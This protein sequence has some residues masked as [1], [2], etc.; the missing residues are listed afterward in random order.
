MRRKGGLSMKKKL[1]IA[2][3]AILAFSAVPAY[4]GVPATPT[5]SKV[6]VNG[7]AKAF[8]AYN[9]KDN[10]YFKLRDIAYVLNGTDASFSVGWDG[11]ANS[12]ALKKGESYAATGSEMKVSGTKD[13]KDAV[14]STSA[15]L[16]DGQKAALKAYTI[17]GNNYFKL[18]DL[19]DALGFSVGWDNASQTISI[20]TGTSTIVK[21]AQKEE[22]T[23]L[24]MA[25]LKEM[26]V[27][28]EVC[29]IFYD[30]YWNDPFFIEAVEFAPDSP[31][32]AIST[33]SV[34]VCGAKAKTDI[35]TGAYAAEIWESDEVTTDFFL[36]YSFPNGVMVLNTEPALPDY[37]KRN[38]ISIE[39]Q[40]QTKEGKLYTCKTNYNLLVEGNGGIDLW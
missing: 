21:P 12:I 5:A 30:S 18:R 13:I 27:D 33:K 37:G 14:E 4:A 23:E 15:I 3:T 8:E 19:G 28:L 26:G 32:K 16:I 34:N 9:I 35:Y 20:T 1:A 36:K 25:E 24:T 39:Y 11:A 2:L 22:K 29:S 40:L 6:T 7:A 38:D 31:F 10:N 17:K